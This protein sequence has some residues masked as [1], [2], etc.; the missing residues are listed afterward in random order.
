MF[1]EEVFLTMAR[2][3]RRFWIETTL[4]L[5]TLLGG[6]L[7]AIWPQWIE[8]TFGLDPDGG[9]G[10]LEW[11]IVAVFFAA[12]VILSLMARSTWHRACIT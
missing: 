9:S 7:T 8:A 4:G 1:N 12:T 5:L 2:V 10:S 6:V 3:P 11:G